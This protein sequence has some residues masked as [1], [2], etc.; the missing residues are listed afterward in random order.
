[1]T[2][3]LAVSDFERTAAELAEM[4]ERIRV[5]TARPDGG[6]FGAV[7]A[8]LKGAG[9]AIDQLT[10]D[11]VAAILEEKRKPIPALEAKVAEAQ[12][13]LNAMQVRAPGG[14]LT[15]PPPFTLSPS[16]ARGG[17]L[18]HPLRVAGRG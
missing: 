4:R 3:Q 7:F 14:P 15:P 16:H 1:V 11:A 10:A 2:A 18:R 12:A 17:G 8:A 5:T 9:E 13:S 6:E